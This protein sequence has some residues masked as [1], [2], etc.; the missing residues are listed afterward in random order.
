MGY[1]HRGKTLD[2]PP[3]INQCKREGT[4]GRSFGWIHLRHP[5]L[6]SALSF[7]LST[8]LDLVGFC[9]EQT[10][11]VLALYYDEL[12]SLIEKQKGNLDLQLLVCC[13]IVCT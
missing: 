4:Q 5:F 10:P 6:Q 3:S 12:A 13:R 11:E 2:M 9:C 1:Y 7:Q 8:L